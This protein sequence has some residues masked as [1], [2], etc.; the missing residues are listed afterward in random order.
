MRQ[1]FLSVLLLL[2]LL[3]EMTAAQADHQ[4]RTVVINGQAGQA[5]I[6]EVEGRPYVD[7]EALA[8]IANGSVSVKANRIVLTL[9]TPNDK[10][11]EQTTTQNTTTPNPVNESALSREFMKAGI[12]AI[13]GLREWASTLAYAIEGGYQVT[14]GW[15]ATY[16]GQ[17]AHSV[18]LASAAAVTDADRNA[19]QL[20]NNEFEAVRDW[21]NQLVE[22]R[23]SMSAGKYAVSADALRNEPLSQKIIACGHFLAPMLGS[24]SF[25][26]DPSCH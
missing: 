5:S 17:A 9:P 7:L 4:R 22:A 13:A 12:E 10:T 1:K 20:L 15:V 26:D 11:S 21:S 3:C 2:V 16:R 6:V 24:G 19:F 23:K 8:Q 14:E 25:Q 18:G